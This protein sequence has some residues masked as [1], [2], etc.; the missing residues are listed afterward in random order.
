MN[1]Y[2]TF[3][4][5]IVLVLTIVSCNSNNANYH[6]NFGKS[7]CY[8]NVDIKTQ[9]TNWWKFNQETSNYKDCID[10]R[11]FVSNSFFYKLGRLGIG[12]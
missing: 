9:I 6:L 4:Y 7:N 10:F 8:E 5:L 2:Y 1:C 12:K 11:S 3:N